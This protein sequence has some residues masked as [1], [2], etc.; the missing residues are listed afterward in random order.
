MPKK[1]RAKSKPRALTDALGTGAVPRH[2]RQSPDR[3]SARRRR[4]R[5]PGTGAGRRQAQELSITEAEAKIKELL[6][7]LEKPQ[8]HILIHRLGGLL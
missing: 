8:Q 4:G 6:S 3:P 1:N 5:V 7:R 2:R